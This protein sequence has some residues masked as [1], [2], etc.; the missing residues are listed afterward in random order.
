MRRWA[1]RLASLLLPIAAGAYLFVLWPVR[2]PH[3]TPY[4]A[5]ETFAIQDVKIYT[6]PSAAPIEHGTVVTRDGLI[7]AVGREETVPPEARTLSCRNCVVT[8]GFWNTHVHFTEPKWSMAAWKRKETLDTQLAEMLTSRGFTTV[9][10][11]GSDLRVTISL[12]R[13]I[14]SGELLGPAIYTAGSSVF[15]A[16]GIPYYLKDSMPSYVQWFMPQ[17]ANPAEAKSIEERNIARGADLLKLF[18]GSY[19]A[20]GRV[21][22]MSEPIASAAV[23]VAHGKGQIAYAHA[24][25]VQGVMVAIASGVDVLAHAPDTT[26]GIDARILESMIRRHMSMIPTL[27]MFAAT[28]TSDTAYLQPIYE[29]VRQFHSLGGELLFGTDVGYMTDYD[30]TDEYQ[31]LRQSGLAAGDILAMLTTAPSSRFGV[32]DRKGTI[33]KGKSADLV[34][35]DADPFVDVRALSSVHYTLRS[36]RLVY[37]RPAA[38][39]TRSPER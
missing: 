26:E 10:D 5:H 18:T 4:S 20:R 28:V 22:P 6:S 29:I 13:R 36:G 31:G 14:E 23:E 24:S 37:S 30:T 3:P 27:K 16:K 7:E 34:V 12:R 35:L 33:G 39:Q 8:A 25:N 32:S 21:L 17:P 19:I 9:V 11:A 38:D 15:P 1:L 2:N